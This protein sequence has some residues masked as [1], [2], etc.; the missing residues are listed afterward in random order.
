MPCNTNNYIPPGTR[1]T[2]KDEQNLLD[3]AV[4]ERLCEESYI[5]HSF[6][7]FFLAVILSLLFLILASPYVDK[8]MAPRIPDPTYRLIAKALLF[9]IIAYIID[10]IM[11]S[12]RSRKNFCQY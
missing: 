4:G 11:M 5:S 10:T 9:F 12:W 1:N 7:L 8:L 2:N 3:F 6:N